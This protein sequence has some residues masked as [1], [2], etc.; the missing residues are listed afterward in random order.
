M[1][2]PSKPAARCAARLAVVGEHA[3]G[4]LVE[5]AALGFR[6]QFDEQLA[7]EALAAAVRVD[8]DGVFADALVDASVW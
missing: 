5:A 6:A 4:E 1:P 2:T 7:A 3:T 8:V